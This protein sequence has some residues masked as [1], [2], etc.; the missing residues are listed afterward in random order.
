MIDTYCPR[1]QRMEGGKR[2]IEGQE[3]FKAKL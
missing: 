3:N 1:G 2:K